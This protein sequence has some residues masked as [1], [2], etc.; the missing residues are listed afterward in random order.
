MPANGDQQ[1][2]Q[3]H[4]QHQQQ[5]QQ[6]LKNEADNQQRGLPGVRGV[7]HGTLHVCGSQR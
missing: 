3:Q 1:Q 5:H 4:Q 6:A 7:G 2:H